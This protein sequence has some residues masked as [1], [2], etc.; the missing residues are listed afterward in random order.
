MWETCGGLFGVS[1][2]IPRPLKGA[3]TVKMA[4]PRHNSEPYCVGREYEVE[5]SLEDWIILMKRVCVAILPEFIS[6]GREA[7]K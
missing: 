1:G 3:Q 4:K 7:S 6:F 2:S 5:Q